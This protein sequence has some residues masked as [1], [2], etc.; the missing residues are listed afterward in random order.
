MTFPTVTGFMRLEDSAGLLRAIFA[1]YPTWNRAIPHQLWSRFLR[2]AQI[3]AISHVSYHCRKLPAF[4]LAEVLI[5]VAMNMESVRLAS[6]DSN[7]SKT[8]SKRKSS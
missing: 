6:E 1:N 2:A 8:H 7:R 5:L 4:T 3:G